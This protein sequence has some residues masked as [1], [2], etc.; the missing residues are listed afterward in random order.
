MAKIAGSTPAGTAECEFSP[1][2]LLEPSTGEAFSL[3]VAVY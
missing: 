3:G 2:L 1:N